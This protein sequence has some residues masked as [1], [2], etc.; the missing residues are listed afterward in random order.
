MNVQESQKK[1]RKK[2]NAVD[3]FLILAILLCIVGAV[4]RMLLGSE[5]GSFTTPVVEEDYIISFKISNIRHIRTIGE[6][7]RNR[8]LFACLI[9][10][11]WLPWRK[12]KKLTE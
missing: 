6:D 5:S 10:L 12:T 7:K 4:L 8:R 1:S 2:L 9:F 11:C 3:W